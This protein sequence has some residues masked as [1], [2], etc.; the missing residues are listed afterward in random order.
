MGQSCS[1]E[2]TTHPYDLAAYP[3]RHILKDGNI[4][5]HISTIKYLSW[6]NVKH[7][8]FHRDW[9]IGNQGKTHYEP[10]RTVQEMKA[11]YRR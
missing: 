9:Q 5:G 8:S 11:F 1:W 10:V 3:R 2:K 6:R 4:G 7:N